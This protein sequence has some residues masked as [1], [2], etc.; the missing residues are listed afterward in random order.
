MQDEQAETSGGAPEPDRTRNAASQP[1]ERR[2]Y[3]RRRLI[4]RAV[5]LA[6][7]APVAAVLLVAVM[8]IG[9]EVAAPSWL[10]ERVEARAEQALAG[11]SLDFGEMTLTV[12]RDLH[13]RVVLRNSVLRDR[14]GI[15]LA[16]VPRIEGLVS[17]R[18]VLQG[19]L[20]AQEVVLSGA[21]VQLRRAADGTV[22]VAFDTAAGEA[23]R[24]DTFL[25]LID[26]LDAMFAR[27][28]LEA[29]EQVRA[30]GLII[31]YS[32]ARAGR[33][34]TVDNGRITLDLRD[35]ATVLS[36][37]V[38]LLSGR[39][40][41]STAEFTYRSPRGSAEAEFG[42][43]ITE[44][45]AA[46]I[47]SQSPLLS[48]LG[49]L[50][51]PISG[52]LR[53]VVDE[54]GAL[55]TASATL[56]I[57]QGRLQPTAQTR[58]IPFEGARTYLSYDP[59]Q[60][61]LGFDLIE[62]DSDWG[63]LSG[64]G[65]AYLREFDQGW[66][67][68]IL[69]QVR[70][71]EMRINP[72]DL[73]PEPREIG[74]A[75]AD[76]RLRLDPFTLDLGQA[77]LENE[78]APL[79][80]SGRV[81]AAPEGWA[82]AVDAAAERLDTRTAFALWPEAFKPRTRDWFA[83]NL[84]GGTLSDL[85]Y[86]H[87]SEPGQAPRTALSLDF[88][89]AAIR[90]L[91]DLPTIE[92]GAGSLSEI[93]RRLV[94]T[95]DR[96]HMAAAQGGRLDLGGSVMTIPRTGPNPPARFDLSIDGTITAAM[97][98]LSGPP[99]NAL[100]GSDL[101]VTLADGRAGI[102]LTLET[103]LKKDV[104]RA[105]RTWQAQARLR[106]VRSEV[107]VPDWALSASALSVQANP[108]GL[109]ISGGVEVDGL[110]VQAVYARA[111]G[112]GSEGTGRI[113]AD[114]PLGP[115][116]LRV[117]DIA[118]PPG[119]V[120]GAG[121]GQLALDLSQDGGPGFTLASDLA[122]V[123]LSL[124]AIGWS[125]PAGATGRLDL[126][127]QL[128]G[129][130]RIDRITLEAAGLSAA[131]AITLA[132]GGGLERARFNRVRIGD[133]FDAPLTLVGRGAGQSAEIR[134]N[135]GT[136]DLRRARFGAG[137]GEAGPMTIAL[138]RLQVS[139]GIALTGFRGDFTGAGGLSGTFTGAVNG[140]T[141]VRG[142]LVPM[143]GRSAVRLRS[144]DA[145]GV[146]RDAGLLGNGFGGE[147]DLTLRPAGAEGAYLGRLEARDLRV[148]DAPALA[149]LLDAISVVGLLAQMGGQGLLFNDVEAEFTLTPD[150]ITVQSASAVG[151]GLGLSLDGVY[152]LAARRMDFQGVISPFYALNGIG[153]FLTRPG[154]GLIGFNFTLQGPVD[155]PRVLVNPLSAL[156]PGMFRDIF[157]RPPP[158]PTQ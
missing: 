55:T 12:G 115:R 148:R 79:S 154:E 107:L 74:A 23:G 149:S 75:S 34:W 122:G 78:G 7:L 67:G 19:R 61:R 66:P 108:D 141:P 18:G 132:P 139:E 65:H 42:A 48:W 83:N 137:R 111:L 99:F 33:N 120:T 76:F 146:F 3:W 133:W 123:G 35:A 88:S 39:D 25:D 157:R 127:G 104:P 51:A 59:A 20:L 110:P 136:L 46:D 9:R 138:D 102:D 22:A 97:S 8:M 150:R 13:P 4:R 82:V 37:H 5:L 64:T 14:D 142:T 73:Y 44:M 36:A 57:G 158:Q 17:P 151:P 53:G 126:A 130:P 10:T 54:A 69:G 15:P 62:V 70:I 125:K 26:Q 100:A 31:N 21:Q 131:G 152:G 98:V 114:V 84:L 52:A 2:R 128:G 45:A 95:L 87:R 140:G 6:V 93:D 116:F 32:D 90:A 106:G 89:G 58:P 101:P 41:V 119:A 1:G 94:V 113:T 109:T 43:T 153:A 86:V 77:V 143:N 16:R 145:G 38:A 155:S 11:G 91:G 81:R 30:T 60:G 56:Q 28:A 40:Y 71:G 50:D 112:P 47:A 156:T 29:L 144:T 63:A 72:A 92:A 134:M 24:A 80:L 85:T 147:M 105:N 124:P 118:L 129:T 27:G 135:G 68:A 49:V 96:G 117:F 103:I 121:T